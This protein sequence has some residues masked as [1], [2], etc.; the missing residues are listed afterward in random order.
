MRFHIIPT[1][2]LFSFSAGAQSANSSITSEDFTS[3]SVASSHLQADAPELSEKTEESH[4]VREWVTVRWRPDDPIYL[5]VVRP[6]N[7]PKPPVIIYLYDY[8]AETDIF[9]D[10]DWCERTTSGGYAAVGFV[11]A[12]S[13]QRYHNRPMNQWFVSELQESLAKSSHDVQIVLDYLAQRGDVDAGHVGIFGVGAGGTIAVM[14][15]SVDSR[16]KAMDVVD[17]WGDWPEWMAKSEVVPGEERPAYLKSDFLNKIAAFDPVQVLP[18]VATANIRLM[19]RRGS[20]SIQVEEAI[21]AALPAGALRVQ[22]NQAQ[23]DIFASSDGYA[24]D[25]V[26][27]Q[28]KLPAGK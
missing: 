9:R 17:P 22:V 10:D 24:F 4:Y 27:Q 25:W 28:L 15:A 7:V 16:I 26:K 19:E 13:G 5:Y 18:H 14:A 2:I 12:L 1:I 6:R 23:L 20:T 11:P 3:A 8:P 21:A